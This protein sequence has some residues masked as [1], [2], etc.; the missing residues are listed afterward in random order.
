MVFRMRHFLSLGMSSLHIDINIKNKVHKL[1]PKV[2]LQSAIILAPSSR[3]YEGRELQVFSCLA[4]D[5]CCPPLD[6]NISNPCLV[7]C[8]NLLSIY[9]FP[10]D[11][12]I[13]TI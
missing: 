2:L 11:A 9:N 4:I 1:L 12:I 10:I 5:K 6:W 13:Q 7:S 8:V 3:V